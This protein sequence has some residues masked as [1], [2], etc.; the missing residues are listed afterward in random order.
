MIIV[1]IIYGSFSKH[2]RGN[3]FAIVVVLSGSVWIQV[4]WMS[5]YTFHP[6]I[7]RQLTLHSLQSQ[8]SA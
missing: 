1:A 3:G 4:F 6:T 2:V 5:K 7:K 8:V